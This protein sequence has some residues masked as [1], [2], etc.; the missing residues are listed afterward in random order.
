MNVLIVDALAANKGRRKFSRDT[1][2]AGPRLVAGVFEKYKVN[3]RITRVEDFI[4]ENEEGV[5]SSDLFLIS[6]MSVDKVA[7]QKAVQKISKKQ[8]NSK[9][10]IG[11]PILSEKD[12]IKEIQFDV[13]VIGEG[14]RIIEELIRCDFDFSFFQ[15]Q[16]SADK[17]S[18]EKK[19][20]ALLI[21]EKS[22]SGTEIFE[23]FIPSTERIL[24]YPDYWFSKVYVE[25]V[26]GCSNHY[27]GELVKTA[28]GCSEC[29]E[30]DDPDTISTGDC[31]ENIPAG[32]GFCSVS[33]TFGAP[34]S[35]KLN[36]VE[37]EVEDLLNKGVRRIVLSAPGF[38]DYFRG[39]KKEEIYSPTKPEANYVEIANLLQSLSEIR[40]NQEK[41]CS[42]S[43]EN[44]KPSLVTKEIASLI[45]KYLPKTS[46]SIGCETFDKSLSNK[47]G[48]PSE[49]NTALEASR[50]FFDEG[51]SPQIY[52]IHSL[53][54]ET[55]KSLEMTKEVVDNKLS[56]FA[57]KITVYRY[58]SLPGSPFTV[59]GVP[60]PTKRHL[61]N[62]RRNE[63]KEAII[64][65]NLEK[66]KQMIGEE[67]IT[68]IAE[69]D[70]VRKNT[71]IGYP[72]F[73]GPAISVYSEKL[74][75]GNTCKIK[76]IDVISDK[77]LEGEIS[78]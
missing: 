76:V 49:P 63:L 2:G 57:D 72:I 32:C 23:E 66:K 74:I 38:L 28:G 9:I 37:K 44:V 7:V 39:R 48:R 40:D 16:E 6:A 19:N 1:I 27:R 47:I 45:G 5:N 62:I 15:E 25:L 20:G 64:Q 43:I 35:K 46:I 33:A 52:L 58:L 10:I 26:R 11:G 18:I 67:M 70:K 17:F 8:Q 36:Q 4:E 24:D 61:L 13:G 22:I 42:I 71:F 78:I 65:F 3:V 41:V 50:F 34:R 31:P 55:V 73:S 21:K 75:I 51:L 56:N 12:L 30:C 53:P 60:L 68:I 14:E 59:T 77:L 29:G 54:G 69:K